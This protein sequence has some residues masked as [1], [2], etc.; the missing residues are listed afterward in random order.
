MEGP[1]CT[2][3][4]VEYV[5]IKNGDGSQWERWRCTS[6]GS[7][8]ERRLSAAGRWAREVLAERKA[9]RVTRM[10]CLAVVWAYVVGGL[11]G[12]AIGWALWA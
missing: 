8:F 12:L 7:V 6:C 4:R 11:L 9:K 2:C 10:A 1:H 3:L 5:P